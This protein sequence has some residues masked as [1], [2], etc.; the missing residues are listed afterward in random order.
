MPSVRVQRVPLPGADQGARRTDRRAALRRRRNLASDPQPVAARPR[1]AVPA[2]AGPG[3][4][5]AARR[6]RRAGTGDPRMTARTA[7]NLMLTVDEAAAMLKI[8]KS[9]AKKLIAAGELPSVKVG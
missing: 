2:R 8:S 5:A 3:R 7:P 9:Y 6:A 4:R 1:R